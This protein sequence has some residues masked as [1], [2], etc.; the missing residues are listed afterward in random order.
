MNALTSFSGCSY[1]TNAFTETNGGKIKLNALTSANYMTLN[2]VEG[3]SV[4]LPALKK[5]TNGSLTVNANASL[6]TPELWTLNNVAVT[7]TAATSEWGHDKLLYVDNSGFNLSGGAQLS[8]NVTNYSSS[9]DRTISVAGEGS[10]L[11]LP[12]LVKATST[13]GYARVYFESTEGATLSMPKISRIVGAAYDNWKLTSASGGEIV[14]PGYFQKSNLTVSLNAS[15]AE[16]DGET[17]LVDDLAPVG[18]F[19]VGAP[20]YAPQ[21]DVNISTPYASGAELEE[22]SWV[23]EAGGKWNEASNW[24][25]GV[26]PGASSK[27]VI[28]LGADQTIALPKGDW[29]VASITCSAALSL[30]GNAKLTVSENSSVTGALALASGAMLTA[31]NGATFS[32]T[33]AVSA[34]GAALVAKEGATLNLPKLTSFNNGSLTMS[35]DGA[36]FS[37]P[38]LTNI[39]NSL[40]AL[41]GGA[42]LTLAVESYAA[43]DYDA[44]RT[45]F[46]VTGEGTKLSLPN[47]TTIKSTT[48]RT[49]ITLSA[50]LGGEIDLPALTEVTAPQYGNSFNITEATGGTINLDALQTIKSNG[51]SFNFST[52]KESRT[53]PALVSAV[54][55]A[56]SVS[57]GRTLSLPE[58]TAFNNGSL[59]MSGEGATFSAPKLTNINNSL[60]AL[61][62]GAQLTLAV[63]SY[64]AAD[65]DAQRTIFSVTGEGTKLSL[66]NLTTIK[67]TTYRT[68]ITLSATLGGEIDLPALTEVTAPQYGNSFNITEATGGTINLDALQ[69]IK[70][71]GCSFN[72]STDKESRTLPAL[73]SAKNTNVTVSAG[74]TLNL[75]ALTTW[76]GGSLTLNANATVNTPVMTALTNVGVTLKSTSST[77]NIPQLTNINNSLFALSDGAQLTLA[78]ES[79]AAADYDA[80]RTIFSVTGEGTKLSLP[81]LTTIKSTTYRTG[82]TLSATLGGEIDLP[83]LTEVT[84]PQYGNSFNITEATGG[85]INLDALQT[86]KSNGC[87]FNFS[88]DKESRTL[89]ALVSAKNLNFTSVPYTT[90]SF[91][92][93]TAWNGGSL[94]VRRESVVSAP[95]LIS[96]TGTI[97]FEG[98]GFKP[99]PFLELTSGSVLQGSGT[100]KTNLTNKGTVKTDVGTFV[101]D[102]SYVQTSSGTVAATIN[103]EMERGDAG[104]APFKVSGTANVAGKI[105][106]VK[107]AGISYGIG[108]GGFT[109]LTADNLVIDE[110]AT[111]SGLDYGGLVVLEPVVTP[112]RLKFNIDYVSGAKVVSV[113][114]CGASSVGASRSYIDVYFDR[115]I[116]RSSFTKD[117]VSVVDPN[118]NAV[119]VYTVSALTSANTSFRVYFNQTER[120]SG[121]Y[122]VEIGPDVLNDEGVVMNQNGAYPNGEDADK[123][124]GTFEIKLADLTPSDVV[125]PTTAALGYPATVSWT[126]TNVGIAGALGSWRDRIYLSK[127]PTLGNKRLELATVSSG[128]GATLGTAIAAGASVSQSATVNIPLDAEGWGPGEYYVIVE[129]DVDGAVLE[130]LETN[131]VAASQKIVLDYAKLP[132]LAVSA[133]KGPK[134]VAPGDEVSI[135]WT[136]TNNGELAT[137]GNWSETVY[138]SFDGTLADAIPLRTVHRSDALA[139]N[140]GAATRSVAV[141]IPTTS[142]S[143][144]FRF[145]VVAD[146]DANVTES[147][148]GNNSA[149][150]SKATLAKKL[151]LSVSETSIDENARQIRAT[152]TRS[153]ELDADAT[154]LVATSDASELAVPASVV[155]PAGQSS[156][157]FYFDA[158]SDDEIDGAQ[159]ATLSVSLDG[160]TGDSATIEIADSDVRVL[161]LSADKYSANEGETINLTVDLGRVAKEDTTVRL[162]VSRGGQL[163]YEPTVVIPAGQSSATVELKVVDDSVPESSENLTITATADDYVSAQLRLTVEDDDEPTISLS[164]VSPYISETAGNNALIGTVTRAEATDSDLRVGL[165]TLDGFGNERFIR[166]PEEVVIKAGETSVDFFVDAIDGWEVTGDVEITVVASGIQENC[167][168]SMEASSAGYTT[169]TLTFL[170]DDCAALALNLDRTILRAG[171]T[172]IATI[173]RD[174][175]AAEPLT[176]TLKSSDPALLAA[177]QTVVIPAGK[178][179]SDPF[180]VVAGSSS[181]AGWATLLASAV[182][183]SSV[184]ATILVTDAE[185]PDLTVSDIDLPYAPYAGT[186]ASIS[187]VVSNRGTA[188]AQAANGW[189]EKVWLSK[190]RT[191]GDD[192]ILLATYAHSDPLSH[193]PGQNAYTRFAEVELPQVVGEYWVVVQV[194]AEGAVA[195]DLLK[196]DNTTASTSELF[197]ASPYFVEVQTDVETTS[198]GAPV[199]LYGKAFRNDVLDENG[200]NTIPAANVD[201]AIHIIAKSSGIVRTITATTNDKGEW[202]AEWKPYVN[203]YGT[204]DVSASHPAL[205]S[206]TRQDSFTVMKLVVD[207]TSKSAN[208]LDGATKSVSF[209]L[210]NP[211]DKPLTG[212]KWEIL[213]KPESLD[214]ELDCAE[215]IA[216]GAS[217]TATATIH[218]LDDSVR[219]GLISLRISADNIRAVDVSIEVS[220]SPLSPSLVFGAALSAGI[221]PGTQKTLKLELTNEGGAETGDVEL[222]FPVDWISCVQGSIL[223]SFAPGETRTIEILVTPPADSELTIWSGNFAVDYADKSTRVPFS[224]RTVSECIGTLTI[225]AVDEWYF[226]DET[227]PTLAGATVVVSDALS[228]DQVASGVTGEDGTFAV[229]TLPE[230]YYKIRVSLD[231]H[232]DYT[233]TIFVQDGENNVQAY[234]QYQAVKYE[235]TVTPTSIEDLYDVE[236]KADFVTNVPKPVVVAEPGKIDLTPLTEV[237]DRIQIDIDFTNYGLIDALDFEFLFDGDGRYKMTPLVDIVDVIPAKSTITVPCVFE[238]ID[239]NVVE[240]P[241]V[242]GATKGGGGKR[243][244]GCSSAT[245]GYVHH[246]ECGGYQG[247]STSIPVVHGG[248]CGG[249]GYASGGSWESH[250]G[251]GGGGRASGGS[252][253]RHS[254]VSV[255][256]SN[257]NDCVCNPKTQ[258]GAINIKW[259]ANLL[260]GKVAKVVSKLNPYL[261]IDVSVGNINLSGGRTQCCQPC[262]KGSGEEL[263]G[264]WK[265]SAEISMDAL[266]IEGFL[267]LRCKLGAKEALECISVPVPVADASLEIKTGSQL[268]LTF[269][270]GAS[271]VWDCDGTISICGSAG[272]SLDSCT[273]VS[274]ELTVNPGMPSEISFAGTLGVETG[275]TA[276]VEWCKG[277]GGSANGCFKGASVSGKLQAKTPGI[278]FEA[279][280]SKELIKGNCDDDSSAWLDF[281]NGEYF[282]FSTADLDGSESLYTWEESLVAALDDLYDFSE[283]ENW[284]PTAADVADGLGYA[285]YD[286]MK[287]ELGL[288]FSATDELTYDEINSIYNAYEHKDDP[289]DSEGTCATVS[290][291]IDQQAVMTRDAF[292]AQLKISNG[293][294]QDL[295][296]VDVDIVILDVNG[297]DVT[298]KFGIKAPTTSGFIGGT[299]SLGGLVGK[300][301]GTANWILVP[302]TELAQNGPEVYYV[303]GYLSY[304]RDGV[305]VTHKMAAAGITVFPQPELELTYFMQR[306]VIGDDPW[307][308]EIEASEPFELA[309]MVK[310]NGAGIAQNLYIESAQPRIVDNEKGLL[311]DFRITGTRVDG[312]NESPSLTVNF[313]D[314]D[315]GEITIG[316]WAMTSSLQGQ[317]ENYDVTFRH[318][319]DFGD[320]QFSIIKKVEILQLIHTV[321]AQNGDAKPD[322]LVNAVADAQDLP[323]TLYLSDGSVE[324]VSLA[325]DVE[326]VG[327]R[328]DDWSLTV[329]AALQQGWNYARLTDERLRLDNFRLTKVV[330]D[331][332]VEIPFESAWTTDRTFKEAGKRPVAEDSLHILDYNEGAAGA[333][334][335]YTLYFASSD[336]T[337]PTIVAIADPGAGVAYRTLPLDSVEFEFS[338]PINAKTLT[339]ANVALTRGG[340]DVDLSGVAFENVSGALY[341]IVNLPSDASKDGEYVLTINTLGVEDLVG[342]AGLDKSFAVSWTTAAEAPIVVA[343]ENAPDGNV[344]AAV[345]SVDVLFSQTLDSQ[346]FTVD[347]LV[348]TRGTEGLNL[349]DPAKVS[350]VSLGGARYRIAGLGDLTGNDGRYFLTVK[351]SGVVGANDATGLG[352]KTLVWR[353]DTTGPTSAVWSGDAAGH[354][355][356]PVYSIDVTF[357]EPIV[358]ESFQLAD[359]TLKRNGKKVKLDSN[360]VMGVVDTTEYDQ[361][362]RIVGLEHFMTED[363]RYEITVNLAGLEDLY[364]NKGVGTSSVAWNYDT[365]SPTLTFDNFATWTNLETIS[366]TGSVSEDD[367]AINVYDAWTNRLLK[368]TKSENG[369][370]SADV[371]LSGDGARELRVTATDRAGNVSERTISVVVDKTSPIVEKVDVVSVASGD[372][373]NALRVV[374]SED[375]K[376]QALIDDGSITDVVALTSGDGA[377]IALDAAAFQYDAKTAT[378]V[379]SLDGFDDATI[380]ALASSTKDGVASATIGLTVDSAKILDKAGNAQR[381]SGAA[382]GS[383][384]PDQIAATETV[385][386][387]N[388]YSAPSLYDWNGDGALDLIVG[389]KCGDGMGRV[390]I[391]LNQGATEELAFTDGFYASYWNAGMGASVEIAVAASG[392]QGAAP[393]IADIT[394]D[395]LDDLLVGL[396]DG[397]IMLY[398]GAELDGERVFSTPELVVVGDGDAKGTLDVGNRAVFDVFDWNADGRNDLVVGGMDGKIRVYV[399]AS[400]TA[401]EYDFQRGVTLTDGTAEIAVESG[402]SAPTIADVNGD[403]YFDV[404]TGNTSGAMLVYLN[405]GT[406]ANPKF[407]TATPIL[408][409][410]GEPVTLGG[411]TRSRPFA[412]DVNGDGIADYLVGSSDGSIG[413]YEGVRLVASNSE[414]EPGEIFSCSISFPFALADPN[415]PVYAA[416]TV[417]RFGVADS[418]DLVVLWSTSDPAEKYEVEY[419]V[420]GSEEWTAAGSFATPFG[421]L[422]GANFN[423]GDV[424]QARVKAVASESKAES[425]WSKVVQYEIVGTRPSFSAA[426]NV[427]EVGGVCAVSVSVESNADAFSR[428]T[429]DWN[430]GSEPVSFVGLSMSRTF[431]HFY[432]TS[433]VFAPILYL[434]GQEGVALDP[435]TVQL[436]SV[437]TLDDAP[438]Q[439]FAE[440]T[441]ADARLDAVFSDLAAEPFV[442]PVMPDRALLAWRGLTASA[443]EAAA[444]SLDRVFADMATDDV[445]LEAELDDELLANLFDD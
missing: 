101:L 369:A 66:P 336:Q 394:G 120:V 351:S 359:V 375:V 43:A 111:Y 296:D 261:D 440:P 132:D 147:N 225:T 143:G 71:N 286:A 428:W 260:A 100:I 75:P 153:G 391:F 404:V 418:G 245:S 182:G 214:V 372:E 289:E 200:E 121:V 173:S 65:Y 284:S 190:T 304:T 47:L 32:A 195:D 84:A 166:L 323:D 318:R 330:R 412:F 324:K 278:D 122:S 12:V 162:Y 422:A 370:F 270:L 155:I 268:T 444:A 205:T 220:V 123:Y 116:Q 264:K 38:E 29:A 168:C 82:I 92:A 22:V 93:L 376:L 50:T 298:S 310:N 235:W 227:K 55:T 175:A 348:L 80:Q 208:V 42:Q 216:G 303:G 273:G 222:A 396:S 86:I 125:A 342:N 430:D 384:V 329:S 28:A 434:D 341:R 64:A 6:A 24:S 104:Y 146:S 78:V 328:R 425:D 118:G 61:S 117:D 400:Q 139:A 144:A 357:D 415:A 189:T 37:A 169:A 427:Q 350:I 327:D 433:G 388:A 31:T 399:D 232:D 326:I 8:L 333:K 17:S 23:G 107:P 152:V 91:P 54:N 311:V 60:F 393:R 419:R 237:G 242:S 271:A 151:F 263:S 231:E 315:P 331:D 5:W 215:L 21:V 320:I 246:W 340:V 405:S 317:F 40:F 301:E 398:R 420:K 382:S 94:T 239:G 292:D 157:V 201:V 33:G 408:D 322:F 90:V 156:A 204:F 179:T 188:I 178:K 34:N 115:P 59:A 281:V 48:Y 112:M 316:Q 15:S 343:F 113:V 150:S 274:A 221:V 275:V 198:V 154:V 14:V 211:T 339:A 74:Q 441:T 160:Y 238:M 262:S 16:I 241:E 403:G 244:G 10:R 297:N 69:T 269:S 57:K 51:C 25:G 358:F 346:T 378:L 192:A 445:E 431:S 73:V 432:A 97:T 381:G 223:E 256:S 247:V 436:G 88:T 299:D 63:E 206:G 163:T 401:G 11:D 253:N 364:G 207:Q 250:G 128:T 89:P 49:G 411:P 306:D 276:N 280:V 360:F 386:S 138:M 279:G 321:D 177:P 437:S 164:F 108:S 119:E 126:T 307:T 435:I 191:L 365:K 224:I 210:K 385:A 219:R 368:T 133:V 183:M 230:G 158:V 72:F 312:K 35:G 70:S 371:Q 226:Y 367:V 99:S 258:E 36:T 354:K 20:K 186:V 417:S 395:G 194:D 335:S 106:L 62:G 39:N 196:V 202:T 1:R 102:G 338:E 252:I 217:Q 277:K 379:V 209:E 140:G 236:V 243:G 228:G 9:V 313:G 52:D 267:G 148:E 197:I 56:F 161:A 187:Y 300:A 414:G 380:K 87:S 383:A 308:D 174:E 325:T 131:N 127:T 255:G 109:V 184:S 334:H 229:A 13:D 387:V 167:G 135:S 83:A 77:F 203:E 136:T 443:P 234:L 159:S 337:P 294:S 349:I 185:A 149:V 103:S 402:R 233:A 345:D 46:S 291:Q 361:R 424:V 110:G 248:R 81:N 2:V 423:V 124:V 199:P 283:L 240:E 295:E 165:S 257:C 7:M 288:S 389:E 44:Q 19:F 18:P 114:P 259:I 213:D 180:Q 352:E 356:V 377:P 58:L 332:G 366:V 98:D 344:V 130:T 373:H 406:N 172:T 68:G 266:T 96:F 67:S 416:P 314:V 193:E 134:T 218:A 374:F 171:A 249:G 362:W 145:L 397:A 105:E 439:L 76:S 137:S 309:V 392:C 265:I 95:A 290:I 353:K 142:R 319:N 79:Y 305:T 251:S 409:A 41:S 287:E 285:T 45:I 421:A 53:L 254:S 141:T 442:G 429:I 413:Y 363:G 272:V 407:K 410:S 212:L 26:V 85:T 302:S 30:E 282:S 129:T 390:K 426:T 170:D 355:N 3:Q 4:S 176:V 293:G 347:D 438:A 27:V 181:E